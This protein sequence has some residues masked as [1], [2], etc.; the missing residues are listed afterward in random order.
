[1]QENSQ[2]GLSQK[3]D[4]DFVLGSSEEEVHHLGELKLLGWEK[5]MGFGF[6]GV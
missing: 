4:E 6:M 1:M 3:W 5:E 2:T